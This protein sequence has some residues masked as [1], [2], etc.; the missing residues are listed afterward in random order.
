[1][2]GDNNPNMVQKAM[3]KHYVSQTVKAVAEVTGPLKS[4]V[5]LSA[6]PISNL[7]CDSNVRDFVSEQISAPPVYDGI[8]PNPVHVDSSGNVKVFCELI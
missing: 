1:M 8:H 5:K 2:P 7:V 3:C 6:I 4:A